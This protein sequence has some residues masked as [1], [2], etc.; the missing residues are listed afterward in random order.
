MPLLLGRDSLPPP[1]AVSR[2]AGWADTARKAQ[3][4]PEC[5]AVPESLAEQ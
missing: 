5:P 4:S 3:G 1:T 2:G